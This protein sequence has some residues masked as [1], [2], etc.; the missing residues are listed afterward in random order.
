VPIVVCVLMFCCVCHWSKDSMTSSKYS[1]DSRVLFVLCSCVYKG[2]STTNWRRDWTFI[3]PMCHPGLR[4]Q[5]NSEEMDR[6]VERN[7]RMRSPS[8][9]AV[10]ASEGDVVSQGEN[11]RMNVSK[12][13]WLKMLGYI[14]TIATFG[15]GFED[16]ATYIKR[17]E[18]CWDVN[19]V[20]RK[21]PFCL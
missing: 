7:E 14:G 16:W 10:Y 5:Q 3:L 17:V 19:N 11:H 6:K 21:F 8:D 20:G 9:C 15:S 2:T 12:L 13:M 4:W 1:S 18:P